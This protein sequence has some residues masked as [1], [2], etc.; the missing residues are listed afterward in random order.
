[1]AYQGSPVSGLVVPED[2]SLIASIHLQQHRLWN[3]IT[4]RSSRRASMETTM[5]PIPTLRAA[6][7]GVWEEIGENSQLRN[8][9]LGLG[10]PASAGD[11]MI[12][13]DLSTPPMGPP[14]S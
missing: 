8:T 5:T 10:T 1:M 14:R 4:D 13:I 3:N 11:D 9:T 6:G 7:G 2:S 12:S